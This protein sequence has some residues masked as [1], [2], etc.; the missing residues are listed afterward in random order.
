MDPWLTAAVYCRVDHTRY[1]LNSYHEHHW[2]RRSH[3]SPVLESPVTHI[4][5]NSF[6]F[7][8]L[9]CLQ[10]LHQII[11]TVAEVV[12]LVLIVT[13]WSKTHPTAHNKTKKKTL[14]LYANI[15]PSLV[16]CPQTT[17]AWINCCFPLLLQKKKL[18]SVYL[19]SPWAQLDLI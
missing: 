17:A 1:G 3:T 6:F 12:L 10:Y 8:L 14:N 19:F 2:Q 13:V 15:I 9:K 16:G 5:V 7:N 18:S 11:C 4:N